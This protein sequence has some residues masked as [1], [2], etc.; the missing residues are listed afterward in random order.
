MTSDILLILLG[1]FYVFAGYFAARVGLTSSLVDRAIE[2][3]TLQKTD[4][5]ETARS[6]WSLAIAA[7]TFLG[8]VLL[9]LR[10]ELAMW[11]FVACA[12]VQ[13][14]YLFVVA[15]NWLDPAD[16]PPESG[17]RQSTNAFVIYAMA[18]A[19][20]VW[21]WQ[22]GTLTPTAAATWIEWAGAA[23]AIAAFGL[24][25]ARALVRRRGSAI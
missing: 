5:L 2:A 9:M 25:V 10:L 4:P 19:L 3:I 7:L 22:A 13:A 11:A 6:R 16:P 14:V 20:V 15:P 21:A 23:A 17:R 18:T 12:A 1:A 8:G 24:Y